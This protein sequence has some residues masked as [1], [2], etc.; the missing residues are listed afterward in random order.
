[1][2]ALKVRFCTLRVVTK[3]K[4]QEKKYISPDLVGRLRSLNGGSP[5][6]SNV[7]VLCTTC[8]GHA[9]LVR[10]CLTI[11]AEATVFSV[12][13]QLQQAPDN[14]LLQEGT[15]EMFGVEAHFRREGTRSTVSGNGAYC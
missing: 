9:E 8:S 7:E 13:L 11:A 6:G 10:S 12:D 5:L 14:Y 15:E 1:M 2:N 3:E 4:N